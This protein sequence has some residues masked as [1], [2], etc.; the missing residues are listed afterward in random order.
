VAGSDHDLDAQLGSFAF[1]SVWNELSEKC[2][3]HAECDPEP[4]ALT[5]SAIWQMKFRIG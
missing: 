1:S 5:H 3:L 4:S 2:N